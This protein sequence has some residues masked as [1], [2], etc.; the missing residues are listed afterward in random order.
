VPAR[1]VKIVT[2]S[3]ARASGEEISR[4]DIHVVP[5]KVIFGTE[6]YTEGVDI[7]S[8]DF[9]RRLAGRDPLPTTS[10]PSVSD[11]TRV[12]QELTERGHPILSIHISSKLSGTV[13][14]A[15][16]ARQELPRAQIEVI[17]CLSLALRM[18]ILPSAQGAARGLG[19]PRLKAS[20][21]RL[22]SSMSPV[23]MLNTL[24]YLWRGGRIGGARALLGT[25][26]R[27][28]PLLDFKDGEVKVLGR[29][30][31]SSQAMEA[32]LGIMENRLKPGVPVHVGVAQTNAPESARM[33]AERVSAAF[34]C[35]ELDI[36][37]LGPVL[38]T[39]LG[40]GFFGAAFYSDEDWQPDRG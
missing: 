1:E 30:R 27:I 28:K 32:I 5:L 34:K 12:Y 8:Q 17:D 19:L 21:D 26:L 29:L 9:Y 25:L 6:I 22:N 4:Y 16:A 13:N 2:D 38:G 31:T 11:F 37:E 15:L 24:E 40:P 20:I 10:Q 39:H 33:L 18:L 35:A 36:V 23:G 7:T 3:T 14:S